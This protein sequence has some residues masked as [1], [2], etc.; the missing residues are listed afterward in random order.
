MPT[1]YYQCG[2]CDS[3]F[4]LDYD[5]SFVN[6]EPQYCPFCA[7]AESLTEDTDID[8]SNDFTDLD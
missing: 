4:A 2:N 8:D 6:D 7:D 5:D 3:D 1:R